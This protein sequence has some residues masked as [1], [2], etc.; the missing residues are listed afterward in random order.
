MNLSSYTI[1]WIDQLV[2]SENERTGWNLTRED[3]IRRGLKLIEE[4]NKTEV[5]KENESL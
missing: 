4:G 3:I 1:T 2:I 5:E